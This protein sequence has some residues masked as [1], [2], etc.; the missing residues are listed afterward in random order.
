MHDESTQMKIVKNTLNQL[1]SNQP[2][3]TC[4]AINHSIMVLKSVH[5]ICLQCVWKYLQSLLWCKGC[6]IL[7]VMAFHV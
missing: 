1:K 7:D 6:Q 5:L 3:N 2:Q 4:V